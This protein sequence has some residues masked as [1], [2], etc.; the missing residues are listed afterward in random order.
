MSVISTENSGFAIEHPDPPNNLE[1]AGVATT[2]SSDYA[3]NVSF[4][5]TRPSMFKNTYTALS[6][7]IAHS[8]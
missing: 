4:S 3:S 2:S 6:D 8:L 1:S 7:H 5:L